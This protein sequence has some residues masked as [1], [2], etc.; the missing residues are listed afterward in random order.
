MPNIEPIYGPPVVCYRAVPDGPA[1]PIDPHVTVWVA[2]LHGRPQLIR[3]GHSAA[4]AVGKVVMAMGDVIGIG[5]HADMG[6][7]DPGGEW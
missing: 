2:W 5:L 6:E 7:G 4:E 1:R 3:R